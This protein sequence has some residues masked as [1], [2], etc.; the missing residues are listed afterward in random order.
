MSTRETLILKGY[1][2][3][4]LTAYALYSLFGFNGIF[5]LNLLTV[6]AMAG[7]VVQQMRRYQVNN[8]LAIVLMTLGFYL[9]SAAFFLERPQV[10]SFL[11]AAILF[12]L[13]ARVR[14]G[15]ELGWTLPLLMLVWANL[16]PGFVVGDLILLC[17]AVGAVLEYRHDLLR[18]RSLLAWVALGMGASLLNPTGALVFV[19]LFS[20][21]QGDW[22]V[23]ILWL[24]IALY[25]VGLWLSR[26]LYW[27]ELIPA[28]FLAGFSLSYMRNVGFFAVAMLPAIGWN[29]QQ[30]STLRGWPLARGFKSLVVLSAAIF[31]S[32]HA[33][34]LWQRRSKEG[35][36]SAFYPAKLISFILA[37]GIQ[38][39]MFNEYNFGGY[40]LWNLYPSHRV[41]IDGR[42]LDANVHRDWKLIAVASLQAEGGRAEFEV[43]LDRYAIDYVVQPLTYFKAGRLTSLLKFLSIKAEW[44]PVYVDPQSYILVRNSPSNAALIARYRL[45][46]GYFYNTVIGYLTANCKRSPARVENHV[47]LAEMLIF[48]G[49]Y[50]EGEERLAVI[51][52]LQP[53]HPDLSVLRHQLAVLRK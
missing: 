4:Q 37:S 13:L 32:W 50:A 2:L 52:R 22:S 39:R 23:V 49:R 7:V 51:A 53:D 6:G 41:F 30:G 44:V 38:G 3:W 46:Q 31:L 21:Q 33:S 15:G 1:W 36:V 45:E 5:L 17:F 28:L 10:V 9:M 43:L 14:D 20:L 19:E 16:H 12:A 11:M 29:W 25:G 40:L 35:S 27:P 24:L 48:V 26:R 8:A 34:E 47:A 42:G 18:L